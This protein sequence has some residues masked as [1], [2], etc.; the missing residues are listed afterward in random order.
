MHDPEDDHVLAFEDVKQPIGPDSG[1]KDLRLA[2]FSG[3]ELLHVGRVGREIDLLQFG[4]DSPLLGG[5]ERFE[6]LL[7]PS[8]QI[9]QG[10]P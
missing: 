1:T 6:V 5:R 10:P 9:D 7:G 3:G 2:A 8:G 4:E